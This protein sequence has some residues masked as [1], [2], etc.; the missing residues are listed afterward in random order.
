MSEHDKWHWQE[1][2][3][4]WKG[5]GIYHV[6]L[7]VPSREPL[8]GSLVIPNNDAK[9]DP[10]FNSVTTNK[11]DIHSAFPVFTELP[12]IRPLSRHGQLDTM[13]HYI[14]MNPQRRLV[15]CRSRRARTHPLSMGIWRR[16]ETCYPCGVRSYEPNGEGNL[17]RIRFFA[18]MTFLKHGHL[19]SQK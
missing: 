4:A 11:V 6:T 17:R 12:F 1:S 19:Q 10:E 18:W 5:V 14:R 16:E 7:V 8:L 13:Y 2:G 3:K 15:W 9:I